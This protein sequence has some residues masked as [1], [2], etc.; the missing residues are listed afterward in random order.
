MKKLLFAIIILFCMLDSQAQIPGFNIG[1]KIGYNTRKLSTDLSTITSDM[2]G[3]MQFGV[4]MRI[5][6]KIYVQPEANYVIKGGKFGLSNGQPDVKLKL[7]TLT[8]PV[9]LGYRVINAKIFNVRVMAGPAFSFIIDKTIPP[10]DNSIFPIH[11]KS[12]IKN[13][14][15]SVQLGGGVDVL[16]F[17]LDVRYE[18]GVDNIY[19]GSQ[20]FSLKNNLLNVSLGFKLL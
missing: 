6:K 4:F 1:P 5:G 3:A 10:T 7:K 13:S 8:I 17:T 11:D 9:M 15:W 14:T 2:D 20:D 12:D 18:I 19:S 16:D